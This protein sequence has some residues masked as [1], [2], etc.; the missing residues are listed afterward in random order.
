MQESAPIASLLLWYPSCGKA[1][2]GP[3][4]K[5]HVYSL[6]YSSLRRNHFT[7]G[8]PDGDE[9]ASRTRLSS[10]QFTTSTRHFGKT[11]NTFGACLLN[12]KPMNINDLT[13]REQRKGTLRQHLPVLPG[14]FPVTSSLTLAGFFLCFFVLAASTVMRP[15]LY[16]AGDSR[17][18]PLLTSQMFPLPTPT[19]L[20][21][22]KESNAFLN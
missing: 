1:A 9:S 5:K 13:I 3:E 4:T 22:E 17:T 16:G 20:G 14:H 12:V 7:T 6:N 2:S 8:P 21:R 15:A 18:H 11:R 19:T 10:K